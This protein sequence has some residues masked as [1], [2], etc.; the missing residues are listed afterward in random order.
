MVRIELGCCTN[1]AQYFRGKPP[2]QAGL[3]RVVCGVPWG[4]VAI[5][6]TRKCPRSR[7]GYEYILTVMDYFTKWAEAYPIRDHK[8]TTFARVLFE[9]CFTRLGIPK[10]IISDQGP[11]FRGELVTELYTSLN[12]D[13]LR[14]SPY[15][16]STNGMVER[17]HRTLNQML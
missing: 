11:E 7:N 2:R 6:I 4:R 3:Q 5:D 14:T 1:C 15:R 17:Y 8:A 12:I 10:E 9:N 16:P 13:K